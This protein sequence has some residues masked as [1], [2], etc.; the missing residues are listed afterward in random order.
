MIITYQGVEFFKVQFGD[1]ILAFNPIS[2]ESKFKTSRFFA[3]VALVTAHN[4]DFNGTENLSYN[5]KDPLVIAGPGE[6]ETKGV[7]IKGYGAKTEYGTKGAEKVNTIY[8]VVLENMTL[9][10]LGA[11]SNEKLTPEFMESIEDIDILFLPIG[12]DG[13]LDPAAAEKLSVALEPKI[14]IP[15]HYGEVGIDGALK[16]FLK[17]AGEENIKPIEKLTIK[18]KD[19]E[20]KKGEVVV[21]EQVNS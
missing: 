17:E 14:I 2:K 20:G 16:K 7:F 5:G 8:T 10:F 11:V 19:L 15:M 1:T 12:G 13:V 6:Y 3:D 18:K 4:P 21:L 9:C